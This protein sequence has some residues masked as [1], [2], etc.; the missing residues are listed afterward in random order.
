MPTTS[1]GFRYPASTSA[2]DI[3]T[4]IGNLA[5]DLNTYATTVNQFITRKDGV[6]VASSISTTAAIGGTPTT[7]LTLTSCLFQ[8]GRAYSVENIGL[9]FGDVSGRLADFSVYKTSTAGTQYVAFGRSYAGIGGQQTN[10]YGRAYVRRSAGTD[11]T[12]DIVL[13]VSTSA[14]TVQH[15]A[16][17][18]RPRALIVRDVGTAAAY[19]YAFDVT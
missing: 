12:T 18:T 6:Q 11:L 16:V 1:L 7:V 19:A 8:A 4:D 3:P 14:G 15:D 9:V 17:S 5:A 10:C 13:S 2:V